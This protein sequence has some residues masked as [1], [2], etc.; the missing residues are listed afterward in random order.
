M[1][2]EKYPYPFEY[3]LHYIL[4]LDDDL[5]GKVHSMTTSSFFFVLADKNVEDICH[6]QKFYILEINI[7]LM[8]VTYC[9][10][11]SISEH[12]DKNTKSVEIVIDRYDVRIG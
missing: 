1:S 8:F 6:F 3:F 9:L 12:T 2:E 4:I 11:T 7:S 10:L 5:S